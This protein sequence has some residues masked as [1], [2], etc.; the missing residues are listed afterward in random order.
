MP[1]FDATAFMRFTGVNMRFRLQVARLICA[2]IYT[3][4]PDHLRYLEN[5]IHGRVGR[6]MF[7]CNGGFMAR[8]VL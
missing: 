4:K 6:R 2:C 8:Q 3:S 1:Q 5:S 7:T